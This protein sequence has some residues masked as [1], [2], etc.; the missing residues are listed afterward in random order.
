MTNQAHLQIGDTWKA[1]QASTF[2]H[3]GL[4]LVETQIQEGCRGRLKSHR[5]AE[6]E[7]DSSTGSRVLGGLPRTQT[8]SIT[9]TKK[10][11]GSG[12][13]VSWK[14]AR[15]FPVQTNKVKARP[16]RGIEIL[17]IFFFFFKLLKR[18]GVFPASFIFFST[19]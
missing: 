8:E 10:E 4:G 18:G 14:G 13:V 3:K 15:K 11:D 9:S 19:R 5:A 7:A 16:S 12:G 1:G 17:R 6:E 2:Q